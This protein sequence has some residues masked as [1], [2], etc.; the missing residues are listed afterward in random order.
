MTR[1]VFTMRN[2]RNK[3][4][5]TCKKTRTFK[6]PLGNNNNSNMTKQK[7]IRKLKNMSSSDR[8]KILEDKGITQNKHTPDNLI[9]AIL[10]T[11]I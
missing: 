4:K 5:W 6:L 10:F 3:R 2:K 9:D 11:L 1:Y 8:R 7:T